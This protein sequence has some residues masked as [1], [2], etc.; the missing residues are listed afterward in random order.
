MEHKWRPR[1]CSEKAIR[2]SKSDLSL[3][4]SPRR[5]ARSAYGALIRKP[6]VHQLHRAALAALIGRAYRAASFT[7]NW[8]QLFLP[9]VQYSVEGKP[10]PIGQARKWVW[11]PL[12][13]LVSQI[14]RRYGFALHALN[15][16]P[17]S[18]Y[19]IAF[20]AALAH[21]ATRSTP[22]KSLY[23][24]LSGPSKIVDG[25]IPKFVA[26]P[27]NKVSQRGGSPVAQHVCRYILPATSHITVYLQ[28]LQMA[29]FA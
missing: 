22:F 17:R 24:S 21:H 16:L 15:T 3:A 7:S 6:G 2:R 8:Q 20:T 25:G 28:I 26:S 23:P 19:S 4:V 9:L 11:N 12:I 29:V 27:P 18:H 14:S 13:C 5:R 1:E 10:P